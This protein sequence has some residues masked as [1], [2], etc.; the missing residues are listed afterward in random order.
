M[1]QKWRSLIAVSL[2]LAAIAF[3]LLLTGASLYG[4]SPECKDILHAELSFL[5]KQPGSVTENDAR[6][7]LWK[8]WHEGTCGTLFLTAF[9]RE[10][11]RTDSVYILEP[12]RKEGTVLKVT[13]RRSAI[14]QL[15]VSAESISYV[16]HVVERVEPQIPY[17]VDTAKT[18]QADGPLPPSEYQL[19]F[20]DEQG[21]IIGEF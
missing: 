21:R 14:P 9:S 3:V 4:Q 15:H 19:R 16:A 1:N 11:Q 18:I 20:R 12:E 7:F 17:N 6:D 8:H 10:G 2:R 5:P 13:L